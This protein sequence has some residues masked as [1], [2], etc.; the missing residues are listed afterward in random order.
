MLRPT[1]VLGLA[2]AFAPALAAQDKPTAEMKTAISG[3]WHLDQARSD[4]IPYD[5][6]AMLIGPS[7]G[8]AVVRVP[9]LLLV[10]VVV[11]A[12]AGAAAVVAVV[13]A[14]WAGAARVGRPTR[15]RPWHG[16]DGAVGPTA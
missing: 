11:V 8:G 5:E 1:M 14:T 2:L 12:A 16:V 7:R 10:V 6:I 15:P 13:A 9:P 3:T 4:T